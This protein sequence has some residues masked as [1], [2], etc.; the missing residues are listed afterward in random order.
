M[1]WDTNDY[2]SSL[3]NLET[4]IRKKAID[5]ANAMIDE[6]YKENQAIPIATKQAKEWYKD[7]SKQEI[8]QVEQMNDYNLRSHD[9]EDKKSRPEL[10]DNDEHV[11]P[12]EDGWAVQAKDAQKAAYVF[13]R[14][15]E[16]IYQAKDIAKNKGT[17]VIIHKQ[18]GE[19]QDQISFSS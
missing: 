3:K 12:H 10:L 14:K 4:A 7:A 17:K 15:Q 13:E 5:I 6:G 8:N 18:D 9:K 19:I 1:P 11:I 16:A 2:P